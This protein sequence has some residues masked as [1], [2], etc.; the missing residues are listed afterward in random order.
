MR[1]GGVG[2]APRGSELFLVLCFDLLDATNE[3]S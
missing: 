1:S 2:I 3:L